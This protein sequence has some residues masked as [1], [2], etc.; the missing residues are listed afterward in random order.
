MSVDEASAVSTS[1]D[2]PKPKRAIS[3]RF[4]IAVILILVV[5][6]FG[7]KRIMT[8]VLYFQE[9]AIVREKINSAVEKDYD[10]DFSGGAEPGMLEGEGE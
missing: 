4:L 5:G 2:V 6:Y 1:A 8:S 10:D 9:R 7:G 3:A